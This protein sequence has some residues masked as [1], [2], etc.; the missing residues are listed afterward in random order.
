MGL[1]KYLPIL[2]FFIGCAPHA[3]GLPSG[4]SPEYERPP[5]RPWDAGRAAA[6]PGQTPSEP[7]DGGAAKPVPSGVL[8][9]ER[10]N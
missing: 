10:R 5:L 8:P 9:A 4:P 1:R 3:A 6:Q 2:A 7:A